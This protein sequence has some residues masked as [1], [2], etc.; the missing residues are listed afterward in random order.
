MIANEMLAVIA[1]G[2]GGYDKLE[3]R[4]VPSPEPGPGEVL[5]GVLAAGINNKEIDTR[6]GWYFSSVKGETASTAS[7]QEADAEHKDDGGWN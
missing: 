1:K 4:S 3:Y 5:L 6:L 7:T 2:D